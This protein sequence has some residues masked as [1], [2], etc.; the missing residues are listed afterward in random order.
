MRLP[1]ERVMS[2]SLWAPRAADRE[3][4]RELDDQLRQVQ[5]LEAVGRLA[6]GV[7]HDFNNLLL[8]IRGYTELAT[9]AL[10]RNLSP[11]EH[12]EGIAAVIDRAQALTRQLLAF[13]RRGDLELERLDLTDVVARMESLLRRL[14]REDIE[15]ASVF[16]ERNVFVHGDRGQL[17]QV[18]ANLAVNAREAMPAG[19]RLTLEVGTA[20]LEADNPGGVPAGRFA[21]LAVS[22]TGTGIDPETAPQIFEP[23]FTTKPEGTGL[24]LAM[25][26]EIVRQSGGSI[27]VYSEPGEGTTFKIYLP[28]AGPRAAAEPLPHGSTDGGAGESILLVEDDPQVREI[29]ARML[30][31]AGYRVLATANGDEALRAA[32]AARRPIDLFLIDLTMPDRGGREV[33]AQ[34]REAYPG[35]AVLHMSGYTDDTVV[36]RGTLEHGAEFIEKP[37]SS[38]QLARR[39][40]EVLDRT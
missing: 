22:D 30:D 34:L 38:G 15:L 8:G 40:R 21:V 10:D 32:H 31:A 11:R 9:R 23:F 27:W 26:H 36:R 13:S 35:T 4:G 19:G 17:E 28:L 2:Q 16:D 29:V 25:V 39:V 6:G 14:I 18:I 20:E 37:F 33:A 5:K 7:A 1:E 3:V 12:I 24:G